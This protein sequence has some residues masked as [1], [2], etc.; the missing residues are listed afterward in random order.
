M[1]NNIQISI[2]TLSKNDQL[3]FLKTLRSVELQ[4]I[5]F[6]IEWI[7]LDG[8]DENINKQNK[9]TI[10]QKFHKKHGIHIRHI[11]S[12]KLKIKGIYPCMNYGKRIAKGIFIIFLNSGDTFFNSNSLKTFFKNSINVGADN[13]LI[14]GQA[15]IVANKKINWLFPG[16]HLKNINI[17]LMFF[18]PNHQTMLISR[19]LAN[20]F[21]FP[22]QYNIIGDGY[23]K[24]NIL[25]KASKVIYIK[26]PLIKFFLDGVSSTKPSKKIL[27]ELLKNQ[28]ISI[29]RKIIFT[30]KY[31]FP[32]RFFSLYYLMQKYKSYL[33]DL[34]I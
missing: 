10:S 4:K 19:D 18:E 9:E 22:T 6:K 20:Q 30:T 27:K 34:L 32:R 33:F 12:N 14:F 29:F 2:I 23:W 26:T 11:N 21:D 15:N 16:K 24:R 3:K 25:R 1:M 7:V 13:S 28:N 8:S 5:D 31:F 17:W